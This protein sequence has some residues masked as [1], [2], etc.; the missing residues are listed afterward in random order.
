MVSNRVTITPSGSEE[1]HVRW[2]RSM[3]GEYHID[4]DLRQPRP[5]LI[6]DGGIR[7]REDKISG[8]YLPPWACGPGQRGGEAVHRRSVRGAEVQ[9]AAA[10]QTAS[11]AWLDAVF[12]FVAE[13]SG[14]T[15]N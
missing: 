6:R 2:G 11:Y 5:Y 8:T 13:T 10:I 12:F 15:R 1:G 3:L 7:R 14:R 4:V 9:R